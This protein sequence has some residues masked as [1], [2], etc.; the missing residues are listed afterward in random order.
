MRPRSIF[1]LDIKEEVHTGYAQF[2][3]IEQIALLRLKKKVFPVL[4]L[5]Y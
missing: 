4:D 5:I 3:C 2:D 1:D